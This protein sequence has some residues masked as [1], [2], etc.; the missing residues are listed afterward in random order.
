MAFGVT[1]LPPTR[2]VGPELVVAQHLDGKRRA[3]RLAW[4][5]NRMLADIYASLDLLER[6]RAFVADHPELKAA[7][8]AGHPSRR[9]GVVGPDTVVSEHLGRR[10]ADAL[11]KPLRR[12]LGAAG[13][14]ETE[15]VL[16]EVFRTGKTH[17]EIVEK[18]SD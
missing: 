12:L 16:R 3:P 10:R 15:P 9:Q 5:V 17:E 7:L 8:E 2:V 14:R 13:F 4:E 11:G 1:G 6:N 18:L